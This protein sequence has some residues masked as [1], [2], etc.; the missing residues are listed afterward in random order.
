MEHIRSIGESTGFFV[1]F[2]QSDYIT[3]LIIL[4]AFKTKNEHRFDLLHNYSAWDILGNALYSCWYLYKIRLIQLLLTLFSV[5]SINFDMNWNYFEP[6][7]CLTWTIS[8]FSCIPVFLHSTKVDHSFFF[9]FISLVY[10]NHLY[11]DNFLWWFWLCISS[12]IR[13]KIKNYSIMLKMT[14]LTFLRQC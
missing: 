5:L 6:S 10:F 4:P 2:P 7:V 9:F 11:H 12:E 13:L 1:C 8:H 14:S 3:L